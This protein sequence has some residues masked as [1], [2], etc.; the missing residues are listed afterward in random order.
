MVTSMA[1]VSD[2]KKSLF[3]ILITVQ[4]IAG[5]C[6]IVPQVYYGAG[7]H[8]EY[9]EI[10][11]FQSSFKLNF[12]T[13][14]LYLVAICLTKI[15]VGFFLLRIAVRPFYRRLIISIMGE[16]ELPHALLQMLTEAGFMAFYTTGCFFTIVLQCTDLRVQWDQTVKGTCWST[17]TLKSLSYTN[18][19]LNILTDVAFSVAI[20]VS[21]R[22]G[23]AF[24]APS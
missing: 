24:L 1:L 16:Y 8:I 20:P 22:Q 4:C 23:I 15:S 12:I 5:Q 10:K 7:R 19:A 6:I 18:Q 21:P 2:Q 9:I 17:R 3:Q 13:Q 11:H 14:P